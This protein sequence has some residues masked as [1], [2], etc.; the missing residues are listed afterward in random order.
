MCICK[1]IER[2]R[3]NAAAP[4]PYQT[5]FIVGHQLRPAHNRGKY[6]P[7]IAELE[8]RCREKGKC[9]LWPQGHRDSKLFHVTISRSQGSSSSQIEG[10][11]YIYAE[12][13]Y[14]DVLASVDTGERS[15][16]KAL[17]GAVEVLL[18]VISAQDLIAKNQVSRRSHSFASITQTHHTD[19]NWPWWAAQKT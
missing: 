8:I 13:K 3:A 10:Y 18:H 9:L 19:D 11:I 7:R 1:Y 16:W 5:R 4:S 17:F 6:R 12:R 14:C 2:E 15:V